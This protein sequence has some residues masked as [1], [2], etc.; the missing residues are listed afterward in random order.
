[1]PDAE[2][3]PLDEAQARDIVRRAGKQLWLAAANYVVP[4]FWAR[5]HDG[6]ASILHNRSGFFIRVAQ[7]TLLVRLQPPR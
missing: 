3:N 2:G 6:G 5:E 7:P 4:V 1:M